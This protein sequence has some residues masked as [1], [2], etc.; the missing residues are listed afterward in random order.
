[1]VVLAV[2]FNRIRYP[3][4]ILCCIPLSVAGMVF[5]LWCSGIPMGATVLVGVL[6]VVSATINDGVLLF[7]SADKLRAARPAASS[8]LEPVVEAARLRLRPRVMT[9]LTTIAGLSPL[10][11]NVGAGGDM[12]QPLAV[13][14]ICGLAME[15]LAALF[16]MPCL[17]L[18]VCRTRQRR[19]SDQDG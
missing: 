9:T 15:I 5:G 4:V 1:M 10:A 18:L 3:V 6:I 19:P 11:L 8:P 12:L 14:A 7:T 17:Y 13:A 16:L 2:Q